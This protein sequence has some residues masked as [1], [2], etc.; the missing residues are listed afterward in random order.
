MFLSFWAGAFFVFVG[1]GALVKK[2]AMEACV[3]MLLIAVSL[4]EDF[5]FFKNEKYIRM[6]EA[7]FSLNDIKAQ[8]NLDEDFI[9]KWRWKIIRQIKTRYPYP[10]ELEFDDWDSAMRFLKDYFSNL[11]DFDKNKNV[12][13]KI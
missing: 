2:Y 5:I 7:G 3:K 8:R 11:N 9:K 6:Q 10:Q 12:N 4:E 13:K 1:S